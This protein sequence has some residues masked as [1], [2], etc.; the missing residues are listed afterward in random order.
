MLTSHIL[1][2]AL[3]NS[4][5]PSL[6]RAAS[7]S[8]M[9]RQVSGQLLR[10]MVWLGFPIA[11]I[12]W[13]VGR[14]AVTLLYGT[15]FCVAGVYL[16]WLSLNVALIYFDAGTVHPLM[17]WGAQ[18]RLFYCTLAGAITNVSLNLLLI[19]RFGPPA[20]ILTTFIAE[21]VVISSGIIARRDYFPLP[22]FKQVLPALVVCISAAVV[23]RW[24]ADVNLWWLGAIA[25][26]AIILVGAAYFERSAF[27]RFRRML[28]KPST[29]YQ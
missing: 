9:A 16:E 7:N 11:A 29:L 2:G 10:G 23:G 1:V 4:F 17:A 24:L 25:S 21:V 26:A 20:A 6:A 18:K 13:A 3:F 12:G 28:W 8:E 14:H 15:E 22:W 27:S 19:P 5:F